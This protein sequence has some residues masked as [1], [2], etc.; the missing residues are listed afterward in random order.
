MNN[1]KNGLNDWRMVLPWHP[2]RVIEDCQQRLREGIVRHAGESRESHEARQK[3]WKISLLGLIWIA[4]R[5]L[6]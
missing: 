1:P 6:N 5:E 2:E 4:K 3:E